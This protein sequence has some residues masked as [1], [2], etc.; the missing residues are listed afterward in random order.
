MTFQNDARWD[1]LHIFGDLS[2][3]YK[4]TFVSE[5]DKRTDDKDKG[6]KIAK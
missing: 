1:T 3:F 2:F 6:V 5:R 4:D